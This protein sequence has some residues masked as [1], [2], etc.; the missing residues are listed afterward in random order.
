MVIDGFQSEN[1]RQ[2]IDDRASSTK[3]L[4][5]LGQKASAGIIQLQCSFLLNTSIEEKEYS[6]LVGIGSGDG[7][8]ETVAFCQWASD[9]IQTG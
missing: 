7:K 1:C 5:P 4:H 9:S 6:R 2:R 3:A 8:I